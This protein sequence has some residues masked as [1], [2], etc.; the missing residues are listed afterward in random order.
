[1]ART[2]QGYNFSM[3]LLQFLIIYTLIACPIIMILWVFKYGND[4]VSERA[5]Y[6]MLAMLLLYVLTLSIVFG[7]R[8]A[9]VWSH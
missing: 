1:M 2:T 6:H 9:C 4:I 8:L 3:T 5:L 7:I